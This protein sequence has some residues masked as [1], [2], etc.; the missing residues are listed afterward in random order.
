MK[1]KSDL[2]HIVLL[3]VIGL[4][5]RLPYLNTIPAYG[6]S[7]ENSISLSIV[8]DYQFPLHNQNPH[9][10]ALSNYLVAFAF[11]TLGRHWWT[12]RTVPLVLGLLTL[13]ATYALTSRWS[14][15]SRG[16]LAALLLACSCYHATMT[17]HFA[18]SNSLTP[19]FT[20]SLLALISRLLFEPTLGAALGAG[21]ALGFAAQTHPTGIIFAPLLLIPLVKLV[22]DKQRKSRIALL[23][24][25]CLAGLLLGFANM[26]AFNLRSG[27]K[28]VTFSLT[29][30]KYALVE[31]STESSYGARLRDLSVL[32]IRIMAGR[33]PDVDGFLVNAKSPLFIIFTVAVIAACVQAVRRRRWFLAAALILGALPIPLLNKSYAWEMGRYIAFLLPIVFALLGMALL[34]LWSYS[35]RRLARMGCIVIVGILIVGPLAEMIRFYQTQLKSGES[36]EVFFEFLEKTQKVARQPIVLIDPKGL[37][38]WMFKEFLIQDDRPVMLMQDGYLGAARPLDYEVVWDRIRTL[39]RANPQQPIVVAVPPSD[40]TEVSSNL[41]LSPLLEQVE[42]KRTSGLE[43]VY[44]LYQVYPP[45]HPDVSPEL[46]LKLASSTQRRRWQLSDVDSLKPAGEHQPGIAGLALTPRPDG[47]FA[48]VYGAADKLNIRVLPDRPVSYAIESQ[49]ELTILSALYTPPTTYEV[50]MKKPGPNSTD[51][52]V[53]WRITES[54]RKIVEW[55]ITGTVQTALLATG[56]T[57]HVHCLAANGTLLNLISYSIASTNRVAQLGTVPIPEREGSDPFPQTALVILDGSPALVQRRTTNLFLL[58]PSAARYQ[59]TALALESTGWGDFS[60]AADAIGGLHFLVSQAKEIRYW[61]LP[62]PQHA[63]SYPTNLEIATGPERIGFMLDGQGRGV[64]IG[65]W[66]D[67]YLGVVESKFGLV[68]PFVAAVVHQEQAPGLSLLRCNAGPAVSVEVAIGVRGPS[69]SVECLRTET[70]A[71]VASL[72]FGAR[73]RVKIEPL[74]DLVGKLGGHAVV[75]SLLCAEDTIYPISYSTLLTMAFDK[76]GAS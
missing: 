75:F 28:S 38:P 70:G 56:D 35:T 19:F 14:D 5:V 24:V 66:R 49:D 51:A 13:W 47:S 17:S 62:H 18:W 1:P 65:L 41:P 72:E 6:E 43:V 21:L 15:R 55:S 9:I 22:R 3:V 48:C 27:F 69:G 10:G 45:N 59:P 26:L 71:S 63:F 67:G 52:L 23:S 60:V 31:E 36:G 74:P 58:K 76:A 40:F 54:G 2:F 44:S 20:T 68:G 8:T 39:Q 4:I 33:T 29:Y 50:L 37:W 30:P 73:E 53:L 46:L 57:L 12:V 25:L 7:N 11:L 61:Y 16:F 42:R 64:G 34:D 32:L